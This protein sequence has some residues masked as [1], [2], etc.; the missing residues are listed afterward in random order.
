MAIETRNGNLYYYKKVR[1]GGRVHSIYMGA[2]ELAELSRL[3]DEADR[4][5]RLS[6]WVETQDAIEAEREDEQVMQ[7]VCAGIEAVA[8]QALE[9]AGFHR[10]SRGPW[11]RK[12]GN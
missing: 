12:R 11:R 1:R 6:S 3:L 5:E 4:N 7:T 10:I 2:G 9:A 8:C